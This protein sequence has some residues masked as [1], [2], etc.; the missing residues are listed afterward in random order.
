M[1]DR[2]FAKIAHTCRA[3]NSGGTRVFEQRRHQLHPEV[4]RCRTDKSA[5]H[6]RHTGDRKHG[7]EKPA[8]TR[9][10]FSIYGTKTTLQ[11]KNPGPIESKEIKTKR[12]SQILTNKPNHLLK[13]K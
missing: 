3:P 5:F 12:K 1:E 8:T 6:R 9:F 11:T 7:K 13:Y 4:S 2:D 10:R